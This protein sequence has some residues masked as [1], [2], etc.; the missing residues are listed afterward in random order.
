MVWLVGRVDDST[1][2]L[3]YYPLEGWIHIIVFVGRV[4][5]VSVV[6]FVGRVDR[7]L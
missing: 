7:G 6:L 1:T 2:N 3:Q 4:D 5:G